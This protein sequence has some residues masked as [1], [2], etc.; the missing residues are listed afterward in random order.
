MGDNVDGSRIA[1]SG[2]LLEDPAESKRGTA[3]RPRGNLG[4]EFLSP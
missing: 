2:T 3:V 4:E 1:S